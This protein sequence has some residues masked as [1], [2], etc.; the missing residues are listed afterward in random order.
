M[1]MTSNLNRHSFV[2]LGV[3]REANDEDS[4]MVLHVP[5]KAIRYNF[6]DD[7]FKTICDFDSNDIDDDKSFPLY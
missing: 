3:V 7:S 4:Y 6:K 2:I 5:G 1:I